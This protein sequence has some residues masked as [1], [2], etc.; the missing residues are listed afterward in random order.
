MKL[1]LNAVFIC[2][3]AILAAACSPSDNDISFIRIR[4]FDFKDIASSNE[5]IPVLPSDYMVEGIF[6]RRSG[7]GMYLAVLRSG[8]VAE[9]VKNR[10]DKS[11]IGRLPK[12]H[13]FAKETPEKMLEKNLEAESCG[14]EITISFR[15]SDK[16]LSAK[17]TRLFIEEFSRFVFDMKKREV[18][19]TL[20]SHK[21]LLA[22]IHSEIT[23]FKA[24]YS[25][26]NN[27]EADFEMMKLLKQK[28][29]LSNS[30]EESVDRLEKLLA[31]MKAENFVAQVVAE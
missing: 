29:D 27:S 21:K 9:K 22:K 7:I 8:I 15:A 1:L 20:E 31:A 3:A 6:L 26:S 5:I 10:L 23:E 28:E 14:N 2:A 12:S 17:I 16:A 25:S 13:S 30:L 24:R 19:D 4:V 18:A 11:D